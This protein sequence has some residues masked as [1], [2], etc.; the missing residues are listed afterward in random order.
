MFQVKSESFMLL[1]L[2]WADFFL[3]L[4][5]TTS[6]HPQCSRPQEVT[7]YMIAVQ[8]IALAINHTY[9]CPED[10]DTNSPLSVNLSP[11]VHI[12]CCGPTGHTMVHISPHC[13]HVSSADEGWPLRKRMGHLAS[14]HKSPTL[15]FTL[16]GGNS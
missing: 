13:Q 6:R 8:Y 12:R 3:S 15:S 16:S 11:G 5:F 4:S 1:L 9:L 10:D 2:K 14:L 7:G